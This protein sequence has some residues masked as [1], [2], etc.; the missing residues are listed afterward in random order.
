MILSLPTRSTLFP[1]TTLFRSTFGGLASDI[2]E[3]TS[4]RR[5]PRLQ[6]L[7]L[8]AG[9]PGYVSS[10]LGDGERRD[11][12]DDPV[13]PIELPTAAATAAGA[14]ELLAPPPRRARSE[15]RRVGI[16]SRSV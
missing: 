1:Y 7:G 16:E 8:L 13:L 5:F 15:E 6:G 12:G 9:C 11:E 3:D 14:A 4:D 10:M 2:L